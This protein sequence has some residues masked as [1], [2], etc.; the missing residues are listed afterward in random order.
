MGNLY[1]IREMSTLSFNERVLQ[2]A[3]DSRNPLMERLRF[4]GIFSSNM[5]EFF[6]VRVASIHRRFEVRN[7][8]GLRVLLEE[9]SRKSRELD[10]RFRK[11]YDSIT[12]ALA[13][14]G[15]RLFTEDDVRD[16][17]DGTGEWLRDYFEHNVLPT[18]VPIILQESRP[19]PALVDSDLYFA[20]KMQGIETRYAILKLPS[21]LPRFVELP[22]GNFMYMDDVIRHN[23]NE[24]FYI[25]P[26]DRVASYAFKFS[27]DAQLDIDDDFSEGHVRKMER[28]L[29]QRKGGRPTRFV[30][31]AEMPADVLSLLQDKLEI[32]QFDTLIAGGR[33]HNMKDLM[34]FPSR[35]PDLSFERM[36]PVN[37]PVID[38]ISKPMLD[39]ITERD[40]LITYPYQSFVDV[41]RLLREAAI[42]P[43]VEEIKL[44]LY[45]AA[46]PS[47][48]VN[49]LL[50]AARNGK[51]VF[52][53]IELQ[54]RFDERNNIEIAR[55]LSEEGATVVYGIPP[56]K[57]HS[58]LLL[59]KR[60]GKYLAG[61]ATGNF[62]EK[63]GELYVD[64]ILLTA[65][66]GVTKEVGRV[67]DFLDEAS[68]MRT[69]SRPKFKHLLVSPFTLRNRVISL[70]ERERSKGEE[71][72]VF[73]K[74]NHLT[75][76]KVIRK[77]AEAADA[78]VTM[79][80]V[81]RTTYA[82]L[83]HPKIRV[84]SIL[85]RFLEHQRCYIFGK[86]G[87]DRQVFMSSAD[88]MERNI[89]WRL[90]VSFPVYDDELARQ[91]VH[92]MALQVQDTYKARVL[93][94]TQSNPYRPRRRS[95]ARA[96]SATYLFM[97]K[98][99]QASAPGKRKPVYKSLPL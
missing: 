94:E 20:I 22:N 60:A 97:Q 61:L 6:K 44:T 63:T 91:V 3:E 9:V 83:P 72:Y 85:D 68:R 88:L 13:R 52:V 74:V 71:G 25:F 79:D 30:Y 86:E 10:K 15:V 38:R 7:R 99:Y 24:V 35:R 36:P 23:L 56:M 31:D 29:K 69:M 50:N 70:I 73:L 12:R 80:F 2:E 90:E 55:L 57:V 75:D 5:D 51:R 93:D 95:S 96:Q 39:T 4:L 87:P 78:G 14:K 66:K 21:E 82:M 34:H 77:I 84:I 98:L 92:M 32:G 76:S 49:A 54:A 11:A 41:I 1:Q 45:R 59:I 47:Q 64:S 16:L 18:L 26:Y 43:Q 62:N 53:S 40:L 58:K 81:V 27:R 89:D 17:R 28:V 33:Y 19:A 65:H 37:H 46:R 8:K 67:F 42:D 48:V